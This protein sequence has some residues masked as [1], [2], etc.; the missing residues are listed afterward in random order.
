M[1]YDLFTPAEIKSAIEGLKGNKAS[2]TDSVFAEHLKYAGAKIH[3]G[4]SCRCRTGAGVV[5]IQ[6][7]CQISTENEYKRQKTRGT[8]CRINHHY[9]NEAGK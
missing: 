4:E 8:I 5:P 6:P 1:Q 9:K 3:V 7:P 2:G